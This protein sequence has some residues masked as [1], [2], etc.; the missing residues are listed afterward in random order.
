MTMTMVSSWRVRR[1]R[2]T[3]NSRSNLSPLDQATIRSET[4]VSG[5]DRRSPARRADAALVQR[6]GDP[7]ERCDTR[8]A[9]FDDDQGLIFVL[10]VGRYRHP[11]T[12]LSL[13][14]CP[15]EN[16]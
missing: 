12:P 6:L 5:A 15:A 1:I 16:S 14:W 2:S 13:G 9:N 3:P 8:G 11:K 7:A 4:R 10:Q